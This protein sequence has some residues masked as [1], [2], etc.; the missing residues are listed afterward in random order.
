MHSNDKGIS[1]DPSGH[2]DSLK[3]GMHLTSSLL[4]SQHLPE[5]QCVVEI[6]PP[7]ICFFPVLHLYLQSSLV[8]KMICGLPEEAA[9]GSL[10]HRSQPAKHIWKWFQR[11]PHSASTEPGFP[12]AWSRGGR[13]PTHSKVDASKGGAVGEQDSLGNGILASRLS[14]PLRFPMGS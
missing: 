13:N 3:I 7:S 9:K 4:P 2:E 1:G 11:P 12:A 10:A 8:F 5:I 14:S 6:H